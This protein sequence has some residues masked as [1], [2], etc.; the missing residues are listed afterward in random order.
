MILVLP[1]IRY[2]EGSHEKSICMGLKT[3]DIK[4]MSKI[5]ALQLLPL[6]EIEKPLERA[7][8]ENPFRY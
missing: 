8:I 3:H 6:Q 7:D 2:G 4:E 5:A 1:R